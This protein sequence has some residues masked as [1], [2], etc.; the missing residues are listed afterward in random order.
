MKKLIKLKLIN[1]KKKPK[2]ILKKIYITKSF[3]IS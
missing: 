2:K 1:L 3:F